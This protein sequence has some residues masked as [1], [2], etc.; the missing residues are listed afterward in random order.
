MDATTDMDARGCVASLAVAP[1]PRGRRQ[2]ARRSR[3]EFYPDDPIAEI[4]DSQDAS[5][6]QERDINLIY[7]TLENSVAWPGDQDAERPRAEP[8][9]RRR[10]A[11]TRTGSR[12][13]WATRAVTVDELLKGPDTG[14][15][16]APGTW[17]SS[18]PRTT[19]SRRASRCATPRAR[20]GSSSSI[21]PAIARWRPGRKSSSRSCSGRSATTCR[22]STSP[23][24]GPTS[25]RS[26]TRRA[27][28]RPAA[29]AAGSSDRT[30]RRCFAKAHREE[31]GSYRV[32]ASKALEGQARRRLQVLR[33]PLRRSERRRAARASPRAARV[34][35]VRGMGEP[36]GLEVDQHAR[37][38]DRSGWQEGRPP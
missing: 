20:S 14:N 36:R 8:E 28:R 34:R 5:G 37:H 18:Q 22:R 17:T 10:S 31:D 1:G 11:R 27:S 7:D 24:S 38:G 30:S 4:V 3:P 16:P 19:A 23:R 15:G 32:I 6:V 29:T 2:R 33:H 21:R 25:W 35:H 9:H 12:T 13:G 26:T